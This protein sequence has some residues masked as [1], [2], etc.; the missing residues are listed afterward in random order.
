M[1]RAHQSVSYIPPIAFPPRSSEAAIHLNLSSLQ[2]PPVKNAAAAT[3]Q[4]AD[5]HTDS[6]P[7]CL[8]FP[9]HQRRDA[10]AVTRQRADLHTDPQ[11]A[12]MLPDPLCTEGILLSMSLEERRQRLLSDKSHSAEQ[13]PAVEVVRLGASNEGVSITT[14]IYHPRRNTRSRDSDSNRNR[15]RE[16]GGDLTMPKPKPNTHPIE[17][18]KRLSPTTPDG[19]V[20][21]QRQEAEQGRAAKRRSANTQLGVVADQ[22]ERQR[23]RGGTG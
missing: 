5:L 19:V 13:L 6:S 8:V 18:T 15:D 7:R 1:I 23:H 4:R 22:G 11:R 14:G 21:D 20:A 3:R 12:A 10:A 9:S 2:Q 16:E 17:A